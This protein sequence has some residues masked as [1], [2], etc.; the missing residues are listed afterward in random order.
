[1]EGLMYGTLK[2]IY[3]GDQKLKLWLQVKIDMLI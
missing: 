2:L 1:M 3:I